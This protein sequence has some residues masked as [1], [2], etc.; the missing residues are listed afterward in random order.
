MVLRASSTDVPSE[1]SYDEGTIYALSSEGGTS[2]T[3][4]A[5]IRI[6]GP[7]AHDALRILLSPRDGVEALES[8]RLPKPRLTSLR[9]LYDPSPP[10]SLSGSTEDVYRERDPLD[11]ALVLLFRAPS[12][13]TGLDSIELHTHGSLA[14]IRGVLSAL[15]ALSLPPYNLHT[16][17]PADHGE[18]TQSAYTNGKFGLL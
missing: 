13:F 8:V 17:R 15:S 14:V 12:S 11:Q 4:V 10:S 9:T 3:A 16:L 6:S 7:Q 2:A 1:S 18:F 5:V